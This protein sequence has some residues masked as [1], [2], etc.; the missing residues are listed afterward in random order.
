MDILDDLKYRGLIYQCSNLEGLRKELKRGKIVLYCGFDPTADSLHAGNLLQILALRRFQEAGHQ[1]IALIGGGTGLIGDPSG[2]KEERVLNPQETVKKWAVLFKKQIGKLLDFKRK[3]N[4]ALLD[5]NYNWLAKIKVI[6]FLRDI[7]KYFTIP[8][9]L[10]KDA[11]KARLET[12][13]SFT[14]FNYMVLQAYDFL[15]L[16]EKYNCQLQIGGSDQWGNITAGI[17]LIKKKTNKEVYG[18]TLPLIS[19]ASGEKF[20]KTES[21]TIWLDPQ[22][23]SPYQFY[24]F[25]VNTDDQ[26]V[27]GYLKYFTFL[28]RQEIENLEKALKQNPE[29]REPQKALAR[30]V[31]TLVH[32]KRMSLAAERVSQKLFYGDL[33]S[34][35]EEELEMIFR[36]TPATLIQKDRGI[37]LIDLLVQAGVCSS[38]RQA[39][40]DTK[41]KTIS[42]NGKLYEDDKMII[43]KSDCFYNKYL[44][45]KKGKRNY[46]FLLWK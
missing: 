15:C 23:T 5:D 27:I 40:E 1:P 28:S 38:K 16:F 24:Q 21:G 12:G 37:N 2:K 36:N 11:V 46:Y 18:L 43:Q 7:G 41:N 26:D 45:I 3:N 20:G 44:I 33:E 13:I 32:G 39:R 42:I 6:D 19:K 9:M 4:P 14:E 8:Y 17:D 35:S 31:T 22:K 34:F 29:K 30:E 10:A 25:W